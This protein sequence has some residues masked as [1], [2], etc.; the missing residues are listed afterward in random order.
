MLRV[1]TG[2]ARVV[3]RANSINGQALAARAGLG[4]AIL[5]TFMGDPDEGLE[6]LFVVPSTEDYH[7]WLLIHADLRQTARVRVFVDYLTEAILAERAM[8]EEAGKR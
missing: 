8:Y 1:L 6:R 5:P 4:I 7:L 2:D 3:Y